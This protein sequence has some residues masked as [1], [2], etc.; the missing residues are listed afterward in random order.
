MKRNFYIGLAG[1]ILSCMLA[2]TA[3]AQSGSLGD[4][5][6]TVRK[7]KDHKPAA[8]KTYDN[9][10]M[11]REE[12]ISVVGNTGQESAENGAQAQ[13]AQNGNAAEQ[14]KAEAPGQSVEEQQKKFAVWKTNI[15]AQREQINLLQRE[16]DVAQREYRLRAASFYAD[17]GNRLRNAGQWDKEDAQYKQQIA[18]KQKA[19]DD[20]KHK[21][22]ETQEQAR[23]AGVPSSM[24]E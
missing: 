23:K 3:G 18:Q 12:G 19:L 13:P 6:R 7:G 22:D 21:L 9:D 16:L 15:A 11:P 10:N 2:A 24:R 8:A 5:A 1:L 20:A 17:A 14:K 4:Y